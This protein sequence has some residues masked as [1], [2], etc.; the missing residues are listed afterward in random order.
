M[1]A[2]V[3]E[4]DTA[5]H[6]AHVVQRLRDCG[7]SHREGAMLG[8][9]AL[10]IEVGRLCRW[11]SECRAVGPRVA[12]PR[13]RSRR[14][15]VFGL[16]RDLLRV[17]RVHDICPL[18]QEEAWQLT[19]PLRI[20]QRARESL[21]LGRLTRFILKKSRTAQPGAAP[22]ILPKPEALNPKPSSVLKI[23]PPVRLLLFRSARRSQTL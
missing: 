3:G 19:T 2:R 16:M 21:Q 6:A 9:C 14:G 17:L 8:G 7:C 11:L 23:E 20:A 22:S 10:Q 12:C 15:R 1:T 4:P 13:L 18:S 5:R